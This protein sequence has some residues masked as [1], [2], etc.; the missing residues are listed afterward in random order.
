MDG[1]LTIKPL[2]SDARRGG[3]RRGSAVRNTIVTDLATSQSVTAAPDATMVRN[4]T[5]PAGPEE[6]SGLAHVI[7]D[8]HS[9]EVFYRCADV[10]S[11]PAVLQTPQAV[12]RHLK[13]Y[14]R[15]AAETAYPHDPQTDFEI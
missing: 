7:L 11:G 4:D 14:A 12:A 2:G 15:S 10:Q 1:G 6:S 5:T 8:A 13:A 3:T 9:R